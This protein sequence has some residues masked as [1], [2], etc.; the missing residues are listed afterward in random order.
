M[1]VAS[2]TILITGGVGY[3]GSHTV[4]ELLQFLHHQQEQS[5]YKVLV[6]DNLSNSTKALFPRMNK[7][8]RETLKVNSDD[9]FDFEQ[10]DITNL[11]DLEGVF[12]KR[13]DNNCP[14]S[15]IIHFAAKKAV[16]ESMSIPISYFE[17]N[18]NGTVYLLKCMEKYDC[19]N[20]IF[21]SSSTV[22]GNNSNCKETDSN[23]FTNPYG[24]TKLCVD[25][26]L[27][28]TAFAKPDWSLISL[29]YFN[30]CGAHNSGLMVEFP[31][32]FPNNLFP[33]IEE[34]AIGKREI[35]NIFGSDYDTRDG[36]CIR[37]YIH[38]VDVAKAHVSALNKLKEV[39]GFEV[40]N[41]GTG[42]GYSVLEIVTTYSKVIGKELPY[43]LVDR[44]AGDVAI[45]QSCPDKANKEL[46]WKAE[47]N[48]EDMCRDSYRWR[49]ANP[50]GFN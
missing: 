47:L 36:T 9:F 38:V 49:S 21:S 19:K 22:Y 42:R 27:K 10:V 23:V 43:K 16:G 24:C 48:L 15:H 12:Q 17:N 32:S 41:L 20:L 4:V 14:I 37:D 29:R 25:Y 44:R 46:N 1:Q 40:Y 5:K 31:T 45:S 33:Y 11:S 35:L 3:I 8:L 28:A 34:L 6:I 39:K 18:I 30:P 50:N 26:I 13:R 2:N 7:I